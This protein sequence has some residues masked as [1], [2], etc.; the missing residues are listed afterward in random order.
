MT[1]E[2]K[3]VQEKDSSKKAE[4]KPEKNKKPSLWSRIKK[5]LKEV[6]SEVSK[7]V[8]PTPK[9][10]LNNTVVVIVVVVLAG[11]FIAAVDTVFKFLA[12]F[13]A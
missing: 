2:N 5:F 11:I 9:Q 6:K 12:G 10:V 4:K 13:I 3:N 8:W 7:V 1:E